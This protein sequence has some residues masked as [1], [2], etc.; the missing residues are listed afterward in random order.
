[1]H[2]E[3]R[4]VME[5]FD[6]RIITY[7]LSKQPRRNPFPYEL[8]RVDGSKVVACWPVVNFA[9]FH[10]PE[11]RLPTNRVLCAGPATRKKGHRDFVDLASSM[12]G[13]GLEFALY[14]K[15]GGL[16]ATQAHKEELGNVV[17]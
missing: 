10:R 8:I 11:R 15:G 2:E 17:N 9:R 1:M 13:S 16:A 6:I 7:G 4:A 14:A 3:M 5:R 12:R